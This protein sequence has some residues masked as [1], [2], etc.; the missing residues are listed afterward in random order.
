MG[1][2]LSRS[3][4]WTASRSPKPG[5]AGRGDEGRGEK[6]DS[7]RSIPELEIDT[8]YFKKGKNSYERSRS[9]STEKLLQSSIYRDLS[10]NGRPKDAP[11]TLSSRDGDYHNEKGATL[12]LSL[13][14]SPTLSVSNSAQNSPRSHHVEN[15]TICVDYLPPTWD[16]QTEYCFPVADIP[17][18]RL[19]PDNMEMWHF[20][21]IQHIADGS[22]A[23]VFRAMLRGERV[24]IKMIRAEVQTD[25][26][27]VHE[28]DVEHG[29]LVRVS[30]PNIIKIMGAGRYP[31]RFVVLEFL[32]G[33]TLGNILGSNIMKPALWER[34]FHK[35]TFG[36][37]NLLVKA[38]D[39]ASALHYLHK[40]VAKGATIIHRGSIFAA[41]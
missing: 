16:P 17:V 41:Q 5:D 2:W 9:A 23:N 7:L 36:F 20:E 39:L 11:A 32:G 31:R 33:G 8:S 14:D 12:R 40:E 28:F 25:L 26:V 6:S 29:I 10:F 27:A 18:A 34:I 21:D 24:V 35:S 30:H 37:F 13:P 4:K 22:N 3:P 1:V 38:R 19:V 15:E